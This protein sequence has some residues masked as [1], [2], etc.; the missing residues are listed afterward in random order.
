[1]LDLI[2]VTTNSKNSAELTG[3]MQSVFSNIDRYKKNRL[4]F[5]FEL[6]TWKYWHIESTLEAKAFRKISCDRICI[7]TFETI[8][9]KISVFRKRLILL[10]LCIWWNL[11][12]TQLLIGKNGYWT[13]I[14][15]YCWKSGLSFPVKKSQNTLP[16]V[17]RNFFSKSP[18]FL[19]NRLRLILEEEKS[20]NYTKTI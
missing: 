18:S 19:R 16:S 7:L 11:T 12:Q 6:K 17:S 5:E 10:F 9:I 1:M 14:V 8:V 15:S 13:I 20:G 4:K 2:C 3:K